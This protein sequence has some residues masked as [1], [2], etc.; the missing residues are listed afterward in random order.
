MAAERALAQSPEM[1][2]FTLSGCEPVPVSRDELATYEG[3]YEYWEAGTAWELRDTSPLHEHPSARLV[4][5][6]QDIA[7]MRGTPIGLYGTADLQERDAKGMRVRAAQADQLIYLECLDV[8]PRVFVVDVFPLPDVVFEVD[9]T[10]DVGDR[11]LDVYAA[12]G[13]PEIWVEV[14]NAHMPSKRKPRGLTIHVLEDGAY[15]PRARS[16]A[17]PTWSAGEIHTALNEPYTSAATVGTLRRVGEAMGRLVGTGPD[18]DPFLGAERSIS[19]LAGRVEGRQEGREAGRQEG[20]RE[21]LV[22]E[23]LSTI[24]RL[25]AARNIRLGARLNEFADRIATMPQDAVLDAALE[26]ADFADFQRRLGL[27]RG[28]PGVYD[29]SLVGEPADRRSWFVGEDA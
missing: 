9:L 8:L 3:R 29:K 1:P 2:G 12:W 24:D 27:G 4:G 14:P 13:V 15:R 19:R 6:V 11:K 23:R 22:K 17:F 5:L 10:T 25:F 18:N 26:C 7:K 28:A 21:G 20:R 16:V